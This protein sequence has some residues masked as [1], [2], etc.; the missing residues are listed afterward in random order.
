LRLMSQLVRTGKMSDIVR[1][2]AANLVQD[3]PQKDW[4][5]E[6]RRL[7]EY[8]RD[9]IR[10]VRDIRGVETL[11]TAER[12]LEQGQGDCDDKSI[13]LASLLEAIG[14]PSRLVAVGFKPGIFSHVFVETKIGSRWLSLETTEPVG[15]GWTPPD[16]KEKMVIYN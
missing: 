5:G 14:H 4:V 10:Y 1:G 13:I 7:F 15:M 8:V 9:S 3:L 16:V 11:H 12:I 6:V 2:M